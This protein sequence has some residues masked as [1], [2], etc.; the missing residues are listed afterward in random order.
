M[1]WLGKLLRRQK[2]I[3]LDSLQDPEKEIQLLA[4]TEVFA[5]SRDNRYRWES[6][7]FASGYRKHRRTMQFRP[8]LS[9]EDETSPLTYEFERIPASALAKYPLSSLKLERDLHMDMLRES[10]RR[11]DAHLARYALASDFLKPND[12]VLD[13]ACG[14]GYGSAILA[15]SNKAL[16]ITGLDISEYAIHYASLNFAA[17]DP[18]LTFCL[19]DVTDLSRFADSSYD[20]VASFETIEHLTDSRPF[21]AEISRVLKPGGRFIGSVPNMW[22]D[23]TGNDPSPYHFQVFDLAKLLEQI[24]EVLTPKSVFAESAGGGARSIAR[25]ELHEVPLDGS[26]NEMPEWWLIYAEKLP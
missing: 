8:F 19:Q 25:R 18:R 9:L 11:S 3:N 23:E 10:G 13:A 22:C 7:F 26:S 14:L 24:G 1:G 16:S 12:C 21:L 15:A 4:D 17:V 5:T 6:L 2:T 20:F